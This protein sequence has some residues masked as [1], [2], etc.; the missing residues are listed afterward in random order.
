MAFKPAATLDGEVSVS[1]VLELTSVLTYYL[2][3][4]KDVSC[5][6]RIYMG[7]RPEGGIH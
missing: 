6:E 4:E 5:F 1:A 3:G 7:Y 2:L